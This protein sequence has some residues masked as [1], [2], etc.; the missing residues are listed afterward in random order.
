MDD[1]QGPGDECREVL[2]ELET[3]LDGECPD[4]FERF[5]QYHLVKCNSCLDRAGFER[6][7]RALVA[8]K[9]KDGAPP[10]LLARVVARL[11]VAQ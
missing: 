2:A 3:Y 8:A 6:E 11:G 5:V 10:G 7:L 4:D 9:C 1:C